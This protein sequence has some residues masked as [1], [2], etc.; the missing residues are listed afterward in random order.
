MATPNGLVGGAPADARSRSKIYR[1]VAVQPGPPY[2]SG[3]VTVS[4]PCFPSRRSQRCCISLPGIAPRAVQRRRSS[5]TFAFIHWRIVSRNANSSSLNSRFTLFSEMS[6]AEQQSVHQ[7]LLAFPIRRTQFVL[8]NLSGAADRQRLRA[9]LDAAWHLVASDFLPAM[10]NDLRLA[11]AD[12]VSQHH[13]RMDGFAPVFIRNT[14]H[15]AL[16]N[17][18]MTV[19]GTFDFHRKNVFTA[20]DHHVLGTI[21]NE[22]EAVFIH[23]AKVAGVQPAIAQGFRS[24]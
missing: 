4:Q 8:Q 24:S 19:D 13:Q 6:A 15:S 9:E 20:A 23:V 22:H 14:D 16:L 12:T 2:C 21:N 10:S 11:G 18:R 5:G 3:Q 7:L 17:R 1:C